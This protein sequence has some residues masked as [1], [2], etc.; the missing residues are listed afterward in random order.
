VITASLSTNRPIILNAYHPHVSSA[1]LQTAK[2]ADLLLYLPCM[3]L[4]SYII[5]NRG[6]RACILFGS[7]LMLIG[8][9][10]RMLVSVDHGN[11]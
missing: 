2:Y 5:D 11:F 8:A 9:N 4:S 10:L 6:L 7:F 3:F 1:M